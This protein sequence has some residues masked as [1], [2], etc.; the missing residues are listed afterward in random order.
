MKSIAELLVTQWDL[1]PGIQ[2][3][4]LNRPFVKITFNSV[5]AAISLGNPYEHEALAT[6]E[7][8]RIVW[9]IRRMYILVHTSAE[10]HFNST[11]WWLYL[12]GCA[13]QWIRER[14]TGKSMHIHVF[15]W[16]RGETT[17]TFLS[18]SDRLSRSGLNIGASWTL[19]CGC[20][21]KAMF[22]VFCKQKLYCKFVFSD[23]NENSTYDTVVIVYCD[24]KNRQSVMLQEWLY[25]WPKIHSESR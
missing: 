10:L 6:K 9:N 12:F 8:V 15:F 18:A 23:Q 20:F 3:A 2:C 7:N 16:K 21:W 13:W 11:T 25:Q 24:C 22:V 1:Q 4:P 5:L 19:P 17:E 14:Q